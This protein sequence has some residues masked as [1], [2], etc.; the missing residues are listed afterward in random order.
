MLQCTW[1][2]C[3]NRKSSVKVVREISCWKPKLKGKSYPGCNLHFDVLHK[4]LRMKT[5]V[6][7]HGSCQ[8]DWMCDTWYDHVKILLKID[9]K[10]LDS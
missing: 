7:Q 8:M 3:N 10:P 9:I 4:C 1:G 6:C 5:H 2:M